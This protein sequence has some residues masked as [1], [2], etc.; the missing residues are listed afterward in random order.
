MEYFLNHM[1][2][3]TITKAA[4][5]VGL[6]PTTLRRY[7]ESNKFCPDSVTEG[8][9]RR[10]SQE[11]LVNFKKG[12]HNARALRYFN[13]LPKPLSP[14]SLAN[15]IAES[16]AKKLNLAANPILITAEKITPTLLISEAIIALRSTTTA[17]LILRTHPFGIE[18]LAVLIEA[19]KETNKPIIFVH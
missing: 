11:S 13:N 5:F 9:H 17:G 15:S 19:G 14:Y 7:D 12:I 1:K 10:Y 6:S 16:W 8:G 3:L 4:A 18:S 2:P